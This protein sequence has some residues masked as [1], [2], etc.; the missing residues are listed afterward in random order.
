MR[1]NPKPFEQYMHFKGKKY[2]IIAV[3]RHSENDEKYVVYQQLYAP[4]EVYVRPLDMFMS[5]VDTQKY[6]NVEQ[7]YRFEKIDNADNITI[8]DT[9]VGDNKNQ[10]EDV[11]TETK[12]EEKA[13][14][15]NTFEN[16]DSTLKTQESEGNIDEI[17]GIDPDVME[18][19]DAKSYDQ[20]LLILSGL[21]RKITDDM[22]N[23]MAVS[24]DTEVKESDD[25][26]K[27]YTELKNSL[28]MMERFECNRLR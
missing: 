6:P 11:N 26:E 17:P 21:H 1:E 4:F 7:T 18:F 25:I 2:Q 28:I 13:G 23:I 5:K 24:L 16:N 15:E 8:E 22:I 10:Q 12:S 9:C 27:R 19:L 3:A 14:L 20:K